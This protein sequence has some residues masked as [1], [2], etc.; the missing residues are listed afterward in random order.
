[1]K[2]QQIPDDGNSGKIKQNKKKTMLAV[3]KRGKPGKSMFKSEFSLILLG[4]ALVTFIVFF[5]F[6]RPSASKTQDPS[7]TYVNIQTLEKRISDIENILHRDKATGKSIVSTNSSAMAE[8][9]PSLASYQN[10][11]ERVETALSVKFNALTKRLDTITKR[12]ALLSKK[13]KNLSRRRNN[14]ST[15]PIKKKKLVKSNTKEIKSIMHKPHKAKVQ[16]KPSIFHTVKKGETLYSIS[17]K[18]KTTVTRLKLFNKLSK[19]SNIYPGEI[20]LVK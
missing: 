4:A 14:L 13:V 18:Y 1:M 15:Q 9:K 7:K 11:V 10:R 19:K 8:S 16:K 12:L 20:L 2:K 6:F 5:I 3:D 17:K